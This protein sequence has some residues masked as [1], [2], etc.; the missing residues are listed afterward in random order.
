MADAMRLDD[1]NCVRRTDN[2]MSEVMTGEMTIAVMMKCVGVS[3][4]D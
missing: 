4:I 3:T 2:G 1:G